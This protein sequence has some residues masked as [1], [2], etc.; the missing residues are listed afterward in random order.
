[1]SEDGYPKDMTSYAVIVHWPV[2]KHVSS[3]S[4]TGDDDRARFLSY[5]KHL[6]ALNPKDDEN[7]FT[8]SVIEQRI[9]VHQN[10]LITVHSTTV[11][12][13]TDY[14]EEAKDAVTLGEPTSHP[15]EERVVK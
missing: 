4:Y 15:K 12:K 1:M 5:V 7:T 14:A 3:V 13:Y 6:I 2:L 10:S 8:A 11:R 9:K